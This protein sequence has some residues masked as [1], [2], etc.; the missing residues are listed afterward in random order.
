MVKVEQGLGNLR[1]EFRREVRS[2]R[3]R[4]RRARKR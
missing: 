1:L 2:E 3:G 4:G